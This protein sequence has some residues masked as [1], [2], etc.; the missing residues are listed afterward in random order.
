MC[1][2]LVDRWNWRR[3]ITYVDF[4]SETCVSKRVLVTG[5]SWDVMGW[6]MKFVMEEEA[7]FP[8]E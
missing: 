5:M 8:R 2:I 4:I 3:A 6:E 1:V 7:S